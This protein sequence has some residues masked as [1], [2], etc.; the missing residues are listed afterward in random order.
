M[1]GTTCYETSMC[2]LFYN[3]LH[4][5][6]ALKSTAAIHKYTEYGTNSYS[7]YKKVFYY[8]DY[9]TCVVVF[10]TAMPYI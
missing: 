2:I 1:G 8:R 10:W 3:I 7:F 4:K 6:L 9:D 5:I